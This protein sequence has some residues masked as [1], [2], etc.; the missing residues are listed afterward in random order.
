LASIPEACRP[1]RIKGIDDLQHW[2]QCLA[3]SY[4]AVAARAVPS[5]AHMRLLSFLTLAVEAMSAFGGSNAAND[6]LGTRTFRR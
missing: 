6:G 3:E 1:A 5:S 2:Q 4:C